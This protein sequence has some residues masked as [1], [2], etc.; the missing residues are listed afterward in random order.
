MRI[1]AALLPVVLALGVVY[2]V[3]GSTYLAIRVAVEGLPPFMMAGTRWLLAAG[4]MFAAAALTRQARPSR[5][6]IVGASV[7][8]LFLLVGGNG[9]V[10][11]A[12]QEIDSGLAALL[13]ASLPLWILAIE[14]VTPGSTRPTATGAA[15]IALGFLGVVV[16]LLPSLQSGAQAALW[17][18]ALVLFGTLLWAIGTLI[19]RRVAVPRSGVYNSAWSMLFASLVFWVL[20][21]GFGELGRIEWAEVPQSAWL[22]T[23]YLVVFGSCV[24]FS[25][26]TWL[27][28]H[29]RPDLLSTYA[30][31]NPVVA[32]LLGALILHEPLTPYTLAG[33]AL[34]VASVALV[35]RGG[36]KPLP[37]PAVPQE[38]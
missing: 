7:T 9:L 11:W 26:Y 18:Q 1:P 3:W 17:A 12:E 2:L 25:C 21:A 30:Y 28:K 16:L 27:V 35:I 36:R 19:G 38:A 29:A 23:G 13:V 14:T 20:S 15:G 34:I 32:V 22:A 5:R 33:A 31:V 10:T 4:I 6:E 37:T 24:A 8:G